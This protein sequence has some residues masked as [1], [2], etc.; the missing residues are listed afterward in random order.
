MEDSSSHGYLQVTLLDR[1][2]GVLFVRND[3]NVTILTCS[4]SPTKCS[5][6]IANPCI[7]TILQ[8]E[9]TIF[10]YLVLV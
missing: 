1:K 2:Q 4:R 5:T 10:I 7:I 8:G 9:Y 3:R 6:S